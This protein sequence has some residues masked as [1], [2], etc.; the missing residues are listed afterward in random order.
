MLPRDVPA[1]IRRDLRSCFG[2]RLSGHRRVDTIVEDLAI[3]E[4][5]WWTPSKINAA[6]LNPL[7]LQIRDIPV[8]FGGKTTTWGELYFGHNRRPRKGWAILAITIA[9]MML[10]AVEDVDRRTHRSTLPRRSRLTEEGPRVIFVPHRKP[11]RR[12]QG[13]GRADSPI[14]RFI[15]LRI[16]SAARRAPG[17]KVPTL[18][19]I[20]RVLRTAAEQ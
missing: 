19:T 1:E 4:R 3:Y 2:N 8:E 14:I 13:F 9:G 5:E 16:K 12:Q 15:H 20:R 17:V 6:R 7:F 18:A 11:F 10:R